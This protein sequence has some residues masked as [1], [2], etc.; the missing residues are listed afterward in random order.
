MVDILSGSCP[1]LKYIDG[2]LSGSGYASGYW[3]CCKQVVLGLVM[4]ELEMKHLNVMQ[5]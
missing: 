2:A 5:K 1:D 3:D 4:L